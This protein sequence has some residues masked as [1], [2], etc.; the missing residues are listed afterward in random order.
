MF[1][2]LFVAL[3]CWEVLCGEREK[4]QAQPEAFVVRVRR[5]A[6]SG[7]NDPSDAVIDIRRVRRGDSARQDVF[8]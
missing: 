5:P 1:L 2:L 3:W 6:R 8:A 7:T 4:K